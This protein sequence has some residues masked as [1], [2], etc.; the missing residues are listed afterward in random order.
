MNADHSPD[1][2]AVTVTP[3]ADRPETA[4]FSAF[5]SLSERGA[6]PAGASERRRKR[7]AEPPRSPAMGFREEASVRLGL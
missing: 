6:C 4:L 2:A 7:A 3:S 5:F 1:A